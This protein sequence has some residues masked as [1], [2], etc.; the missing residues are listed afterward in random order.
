M[1][2]ATGLQESPLTSMGCSDAWYS[3][4]IYMAVLYFVIALT[5]MILTRETG[6]L[7]EISIFH[8]DLVISLLLPA[9]LHRLVILRV[10]VPLQMK[11]PTA[12][13]WVHFSTCQLSGY[14]DFHLQ[15]NNV[16]ALFITIYAEIYI[17]R[18]ARLK[19]YR[20]S[21]QCRALKL[22]LLQWIMGFS[23]AFFSAW[24]GL[25][26][27]S[28]SSN[29]CCFAPLYR[30]NLQQVLLHLSLLTYLSSACLIIWLTKRRVLR[31]IVTAKHR[32]EQTI[33]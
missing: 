21:G 10:A 24:F 3:V 13:G 1:G 28:S 14:L 22:I 5:C 26:R 25:F 18:N 15:I 16:L 9:L 7:K 33:V 2:L 4:T 27:L 23:I 6:R 19:C 12:S 17:R 30:K 32:Q 11:L 29:I 31:L 8:D 20:K